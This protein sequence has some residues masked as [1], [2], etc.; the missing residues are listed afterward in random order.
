MGT[1]KKLKLKM[2]LDK[3]FRKTLLR[4]TRNE[5]L[6]DIDGDKDADVAL[7]DTTGDGNIDTVAVDL[8]GDGEFNLYFSDI[9]GNGIPDM[10]LY[11]E[12]GDGRAEIM[13]VGKEIEEEIRAAANAILTM[14]EA[15]EYIAKDLEE[16]LDRLDKDVRVARKALKKRSR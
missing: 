7:I 16:S 4:G 9:D 14:L 1:L 8:T 2:K 3:D 13:A 5:I 10:M 15:E 6:V 11:D 12:D